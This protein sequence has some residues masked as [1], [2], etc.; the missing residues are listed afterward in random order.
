M[1]GAAAQTDGVPDAPETQTAEVFFLLG[2]LT[3]DLTFFL[4][5]VAPGLRPAPGR[6]PPLHPF[7]P[8]ISRR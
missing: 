8:T 5:V 3:L 4:I 7:F 2:F 1:F 6:H